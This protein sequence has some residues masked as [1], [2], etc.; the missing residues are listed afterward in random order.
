LSD[1]VKAEYRPC[2]LC[3]A[4]RAENGTPVFCFDASGEAY[5]TGTCRSVEKDKYYTETTKAQA[6]QAGYTPCSVCGGD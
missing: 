6:E 2:P 4:K 3:G 5:H 1:E